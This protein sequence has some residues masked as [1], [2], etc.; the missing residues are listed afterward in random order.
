MIDEDLFVYIVERFDGFSRLVEQFTAVEERAQYIS[1]HT[2]EINLRGLDMLANQL[3][4]EKMHR[5]VKDVNEVYESALILLAS[6]ANRIIRDEAMLC[7]LDPSHSINTIVNDAN[8]GAL[9]AM[10]IPIVDHANYDIDF[11]SM[12]VLPSGA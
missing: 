3:T 6:E 9:K 1:R 8:V 12:E 7:V 11:N 4:L 5:R 2:H 10:S